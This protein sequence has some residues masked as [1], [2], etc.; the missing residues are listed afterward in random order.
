MGVPVDFDKDGNA[1]V[2]EILFPEI[3]IKRFR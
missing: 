1:A 3:T 2:L